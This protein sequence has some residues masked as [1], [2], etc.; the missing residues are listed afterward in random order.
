MCIWCNFEDV[1]HWEFVPNGREIDAHL[2]SHEILRRGCPALVKRNRV[3]LQQDNARP[4]TARTT[5]TKNQELRGIE[6]LP[7][8]AYS[9]DLAPSDRHLFLTMAHFFRGRYLEYIEAVELG[10]VEFF[11][12]KT[13]YWYRRGIIN[14]AERWLKTL[15]SEGLFFEERFNFLS[16][17]IP[18]KILFKKIHYL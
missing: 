14:L 1:I 2:S 4:H 12:S 3:L 13:R 9:P 10:L 15:E 5:M 18:N 11:A 8:Q 16:E 7:R 17:I 6:L